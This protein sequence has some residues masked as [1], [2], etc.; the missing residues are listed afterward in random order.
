MLE[1]MR[2]SRALNADGVVFFSSG[3]LSQPFL[4]GLKAAR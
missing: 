3:S 4:D 2:I 1:Q